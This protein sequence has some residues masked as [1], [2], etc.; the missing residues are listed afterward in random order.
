[1]KKLICWL[2]AVLMLLSCSLTALA[3]EE[4]TV[5]TVNGEAIAYH[6]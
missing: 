2:L 4:Q 1:M 6:E 3:T 5:V